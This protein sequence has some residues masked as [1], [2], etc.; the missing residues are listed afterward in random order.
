MSHIY[1]RNTGKIRC[2][3]KGQ[4]SISYILADYLRC[5]VIP[6]VLLWAAASVLVPG[7]EKTST[8]TPADPGANYRSSV[9]GPWWSWFHGVGRDPSNADL[10][11]EGSAFHVV[12]IP[13]NQLGDAARAGTGGQRLLRRGRLAVTKHHTSFFACI[14]VCIYIY[15]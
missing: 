1:C 6:C 15:T 2:H 7:F 9:G 8:A 12:S 13:S 4:I 3:M 11:G 14:C 10:A 5:L